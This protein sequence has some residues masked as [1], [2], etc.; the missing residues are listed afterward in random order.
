MKNLSKTIS[1]KLLPKVSNPAQY[2]GGEVNQIRKDWDQC[3]VKVAL[4][5]PD[6][7][8]MGMSNIGYSILYHAINLL[9]DTLA[10]RT[11]C[12]WFDAGEIMKE[13]GIPLFSWE[14]RMPVKEFDF[15]GITMQHELS[16]S[17][18]LY[19]LDLSQIP[20]RAENRLESDPII[21]GGGPIADCCEPVADFF[22]CILL[23][24]GEEVFPQILELYRQCKNDKFS[25]K[26]I[27]ISIAKKF[28]TVYVPQFYK[29]EYAENNTILSR[30][31]IEDGIPEII[32][33]AHLLDMDNAPYSNA[34]LVANTDTPHDR[35]ALEIMRGC[36]CRCAFC[37]AGHTKGK[38]RCRSIDN[39]LKIAS[40]SYSKTGHDTIS[41]L[42]LSS[43]DYP[44]LAEL[45][46]KMYDQFEGCNVSISLPSLRV[47][48]QLHELPAKITKTRKEGL[49]IA[50]ETAAVRIR[51]A[52]GKKVTDTDLEE[53]M[54][55]AYKAGFLKV[56]L[57]FMIGFPGETEEDLLGII[58]LASRISY[59]RR[60]VHGTP[61]SVTASVSWLV[62]KPHTPFAWIG[63]RNFD[64][65]MNARR[66]LID[67]CKKLRKVSV[68]VKFHY[69]ERS[70]LETILSRGDR[71]ISYAIEE[72]YK[73]GAKFDCWDEGFQYDRY[74]EAFAKLG[75]SPDFYTERES[76]IDEIQPWYHLGNDNLES[77]YSRYC[78]IIESINTESE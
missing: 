46:E 47:D 63:Q 33:R 42:S 70:I 54:I 53:T 69:M 31:V 22:D 4:A 58:K 68:K 19:L 41:L 36:P 57:Y 48:K 9:D 32:N 77:L 72:A 29:F 64:Y 24:D 75:I 16:Y 15:V 45:A 12:P 59:L 61:A 55:E 26:N 13:Q 1:H 44:N 10:E 3:D 39:L 14:N 6:V 38:L 35:I 60:Q 27:L 49:T 30:S 76:S 67:Q 11:Y 18:I 71:R 5:F 23:G 20:F 17:N 43:S 25:R 21:I 73:L 50:V 56:K 40:E 28:D 37:H 51:K 65:F 7:Y 2:I 74:L 62:P 34:P 78:K 66:L 8:S 52:I